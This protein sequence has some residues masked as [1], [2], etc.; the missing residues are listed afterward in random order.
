MERG[1]FLAVALLAIAQAGCATE[2]ADVERTRTV[3]GQGFVVE[4]DGTLEPAE[5]AALLQ[6]LAESRAKI[7]HLFGK[8]AAIGDFRTW[9]ERSE[10]ACAGAQLPAPPVEIRV[11]VVK[12]EGRCHA[13]ETGL[14]IR[15]DHLKRKDATHELVHYLAGGSWRPIDEGLAVWLTEKLQGPAWGVPVDVRSRVYFDLGMDDGLDRERMRLGMNRRDYDL[16]GSFVKFLI[17]EKGLDAFMVLYRSAPGDYH[18]VFGMP[19]QDLLAKWRERIHAMNVRQD[20]SYYRFK[21][22]LAN[23]RSADDHAADRS[24]QGG[25]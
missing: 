3:H 25:H 4:D 19:E 13:D 6:E 11:V 16:A 17:D 9:K 21:D 10:A 24:L 22:Y 18:T 7:L 5:E 8:T 1:T 20:A 2:S 14:T 15:R 12:K 23:L